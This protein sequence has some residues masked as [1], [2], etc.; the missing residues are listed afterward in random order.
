MGGRGG[1]ETW[2]GRKTGYLLWCSAVHER[3]FVTTGV[4]TWAK[5]CFS[6][7]RELPQ[8]CVL[9]S[10]RFRFLILRGDVSR[11]CRNWFTDR[12]SIPAIFSS[13]F[14]GPCLWQFSNQF[15]KSIHLPL[16]RKH[17]LLPD[18]LLPVFL[19]C[20]KLSSGNLRIKSLSFP[21]PLPSLPASPQN[22]NAGEK[23][24]SRS[25][26]S[27]VLAAS[28]WKLFHRDIWNQRRRW[29]E[30]WTASS[31]LALPPGL[32]WKVLIN[33]ALSFRDYWPINSASNRAN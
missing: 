31:H 22:E 6:C 21:F 23:S 5:N 8:C 26:K 11:S 15:A 19:F 28:P 30:N 12:L 20:G 17:F 29:S 24:E 27:F 33:C 2:R 10:P 32:A 13:Y 18:L 1:K 9:S 25:E 16:S 14:E 3:K 4:G 7:W